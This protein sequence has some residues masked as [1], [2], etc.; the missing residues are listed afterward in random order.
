MS[1]SLKSGL[2]STGGQRTI[3][4]AVL[5]LL[6]LIAWLTWEARASDRSRRVAAEGVLRDYAA[7]AAWQFERAV[8][9]YL[10]SHL[11]MSLSAVPRDPVR[12]GAPLPHPSLLSESVARCRCGFQEEV[13]FAFAVD[14]S[15]ETIMVDRPLDPELES[16]LSRF[17]GIGH[18]L[19]RGIAVARDRRDEDG[20]GPG[21]LRFDSLAGSPYVL[22]L[23]VVRDRSESPRA[24]YGLAA[25]PRHFTEDFAR[26]VRDQPL[27][28]PSLIGELPNDSALWIRISH[29]AAGT[30]LGTG[31]DSSRATSTVVTD[32]VAPSLGGL[33][34]TVAP[35]REIAQSLLIGGVPSSR[36]PLYLSL[37][38][39]AVALTGIALVQLRRARELE[40]LR[41]RFVASVSH[42]I[43]TPLAQIAMFSE[44]LMLERERSPEERR[45]FSRVIFRE[46]KRLSNLVQGVL[47][48]ARADARTAQVTME[49]VDLSAEVRE[50]VEGFAPLAAAADVRLDPLLTGP[51]PARVDAGAFR[52]ILL[53]LLDNAVK[54][55]PRGQTVTVRLDRADGEVLVSVEDQGPGIP[56]ADRDRVFEAFTRLERSKET[57]VAGAGIGLSVVRELV[58]AHGGRV[59]IDAA[60]NGARVTFSVP[61]A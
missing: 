2:Q 44:T 48:F 27:L 33:I 19:G 55:G 50:V 61:A 21:V 20:R 36:L 51:A 38:T 5:A 14:L 43:R 22:A 34:L 10:S 26:I 23:A 6:A 54:Y 53:N 31:P 32:T 12:P 56:H 17:V 42:E 47:H 35:R 18:E 29:P 24:L 4:A 49:R 57:R 40:R 37:L 7:F 30:I 13:R 25:D 60:D 3:S 28:P 15:A 1:A 41:A 45:H 59:W 52:Q 39:L 16:A 8:R 11:S 46:S 58:S 9:G